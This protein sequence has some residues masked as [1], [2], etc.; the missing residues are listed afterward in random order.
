M[1]FSCTL[2]RQHGGQIHLTHRDTG[3][4]VATLTLPRA[5]EG[6]RPASRP[7]PSR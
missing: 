2:A 3:G 1:P 6:S 5:A 7:Q 4:T